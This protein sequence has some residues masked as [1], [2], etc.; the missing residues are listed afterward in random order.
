M[1]LFWV[2]PKECEKTLVWFCQVWRCCPLWMS[3]AS[4][5]PWRKCTLTS[6]LKRVRIGGVLLKNWGVLLENWGVLLKSWGVLLPPMYFTLNEH[7]G[8]LDVWLGLFFMGAAGS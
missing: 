4:E 3:G 1:G 7:R 6:L 5:L 2:F 8:V